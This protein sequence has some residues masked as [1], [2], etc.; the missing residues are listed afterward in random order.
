MF[1]STCNTYFCIVF[2][3]G[4]RSNVLAVFF[5]KHWWDVKT[6]MENRSMGHLPESAQIELSLTRLAQP[7][8]RRSSQVSKSPKPHLSPPRSP[9]RPAVDR[10]RRPNRAVAHGGPL[11]RLCSSRLP[12]QRC[13]SSLSLSLTRRTGQGSLSDPTSRPLAYSSLYVS[14]VSCRDRFSLLGCWLERKL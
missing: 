11:S 10:L 7:N 5:E 2:Y 8:P 12:R 3:L 4:T 13:A 14:L 6:K 9:D 1:C